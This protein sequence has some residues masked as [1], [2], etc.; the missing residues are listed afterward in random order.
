MQ[1]SKAAALKPLV[2]AAILSTVLV[3]C[4]TSTPSTAVKQVCVQQEAVV[5]SRMARSTC[6]PAV[7]DS[8]DESKKT[9][10]AQ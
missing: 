2:L 3:G 5:G 7:D 4:V 1:N 8:K 6:K 10:T 9:A